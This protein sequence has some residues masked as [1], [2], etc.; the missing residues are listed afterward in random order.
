VPRSGCR[1]PCGKLISAGHRLFGC[2]VGNLAGPAAGGCHHPGPDPGKGRGRAGGEHTDCRAGTNSAV[3]VLN[4]G[5]ATP[6]GNRRVATSF[7][8]SAELMTAPSATAGGRRIELAPSPHSPQHAATGRRPRT[9]TVPPNRPIAIGVRVEHNPRAVNSDLVSAPLSGDT[10][11]PDRGLLAERR[12]D[13]RGH[14]SASLR[15]RNWIARIA[16]QCGS[17]QSRATCGDPSGYG[18]GMVH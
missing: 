2:T 6:S 16:R 7:R 15:I 8:A 3:A 11:S 9:V 14:G 1:N 13:V 18:M 17:A 5:I 10:G 12:Q 4:N